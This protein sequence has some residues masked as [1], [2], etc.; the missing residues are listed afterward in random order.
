[1]PWGQSLSWVGTRF[2]PW[3][4]GSNEPMG[5]VLVEREFGRYSHRWL[6]PSTERPEGRRGEFR[7]FRSEIKVAAGARLASLRS[8][9][10]AGEGSWDALIY[11]SDV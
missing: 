7:S 8:A 2:V 4:G 11:G 5:A 1:M 3:V 9:T 6:L 10:A